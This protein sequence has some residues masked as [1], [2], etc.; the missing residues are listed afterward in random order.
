MLK[1]HNPDIS[2]WPLRYATHTHTNTHTHSLATHVGCSGGMR[3][4][5][6]SRDCF[7]GQGCKSTGRQ[8]PR[9]KLTSQ[10]APSQ[11]PYVVQIIVPWS[12]LRPSLFLW[13]CLT[14]LGS[15]QT[16]VDQV[17]LRQG[18]HNDQPRLYVL[19]STAS[20]VVPF[21]GLPRTC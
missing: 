15:C 3:C 19:L 14:F 7:C 8:L 13:L 9:S 2:V 17:L 5:C 20:V 10:T 12:E 1:A 4:M 18:P 21:I 6:G 11:V 16:F